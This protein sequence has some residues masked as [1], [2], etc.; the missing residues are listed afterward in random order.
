[1]SCLEANKTLSK[2]VRLRCGYGKIGFRYICDV[3]TYRKALKQP[4]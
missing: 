2:D 4:F 3:E 1:M